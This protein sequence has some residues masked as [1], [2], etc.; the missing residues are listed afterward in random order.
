MRALFPSCV[1]FRRMQFKIVHGS[2]FINME[3]TCRLAVRAHRDALIALRSF[4][5]LLVNNKVSLDALI[6][7]VKTVDSNIKTA[8]RVYK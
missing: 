6:K 8:D 3:I 1:P 2:K 7:A 4:W 5:M